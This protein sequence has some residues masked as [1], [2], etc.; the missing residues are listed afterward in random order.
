MAGVEEVDSEKSL[1]EK[2]WI[3]RIARASLRTMGTSIKEREGEQD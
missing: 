2:Q 3:S 1:L